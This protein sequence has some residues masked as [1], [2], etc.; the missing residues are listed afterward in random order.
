MTPPSDPLASARL[1]EALLAIPYL[2]LGASHIVQPAMWREYFTR[3]YA[4]GAPGLVTRTFT[5]ELWPALLIVVF[6][7]V[8]TGPAALLTTFGHAL[9]V[10]I[11][12]SMLIPSVGLRS[13]RMAERGDTG[14]RVGGC[15]LVALGLLCVYLRWAA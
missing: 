9:L 4:E 1:V 11:V 6:H 13:L 10:K 15:V 2:V 7:Q 3:L 8:W 5:L 14:F 12:L